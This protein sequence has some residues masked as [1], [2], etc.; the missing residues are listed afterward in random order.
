MRGS[1]TANVVVTAVILSS[2]PSL[3]VVRQ[4]RNMT[5]EGIVDNIC[6]CH[7]CAI[8]VAIERR[9]YE[10]KKGLVIEASLLSLPLYL[11]PSHGAMHNQ[12]VHLRTL[13]LRN[14]ARVPAHKGLVDNIRCC[15]SHFV[16]VVAIVRRRYETKEELMDNICCCHGLLWSPSCDRNAIISC[17][18]A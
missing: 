7:S 14:E 13:L 3:F 18:R 12:L 5:H 17:A 6:C 2:S 10:T 4:Q 1:L 16:V 11:S 9:R 8:V 15:L